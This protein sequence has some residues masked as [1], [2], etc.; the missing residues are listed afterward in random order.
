MSRNLF[1]IF[2]LEPRLFAKNAAG[3]PLTGQAMANGNSHRP[4]VAFD[5]ELSATAGC[6]P[7]GHV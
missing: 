2:L 4:A 3:P 7:L 1:D 6:C 5:G